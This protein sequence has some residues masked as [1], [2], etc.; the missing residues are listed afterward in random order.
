MKRMIQKEKNDNSVIIKNDEGTEGELYVYVNVPKTLL[1]FLFYLNLHET[2]LSLL[3][4]FPNI[5]KCLFQRVPLHF[6]KS[7]L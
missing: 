2:T 4:D 5:H 6:Y 3:L 1:M 7:I